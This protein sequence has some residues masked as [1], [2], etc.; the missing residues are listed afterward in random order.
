MKNLDLHFLKKLLRYEKMAT[1]SKRTQSKYSR[2]VQIA[3]KQKS[4]ICRL[5][6]KSLQSRLEESS[7]Y[8]KSFANLRIFN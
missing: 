6:S 3:F 5:S 1:R 4:P 7:R 2:N 8:K